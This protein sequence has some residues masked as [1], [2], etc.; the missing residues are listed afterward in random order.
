MRT[1]CC[2]YF[3]WADFSLSNL[4]KISKTSVRSLHQ[5]QSS[6]NTNKKSNASEKKRSGHKG[7]HAK[8]NSSVNQPYT[9]RKIPY[10]LS[11]LTGNLAEEVPSGFRISP[12][13]FEETLTIPKVSKIWWE[14]LKI[15]RKLLRQI[16]RQIK[17]GLCW[18]FA[19]NPVA[20]GVAKGANDGRVQIRENLQ[21]GTW[22]GAW[23]P[24]SR[25]A[26]VKKS[27]CGTCPLRNG[28]RTL[29]IQ[30]DC[31]LV[32]IAKYQHR[33]TLP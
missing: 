10:P 25:G 26:C 2:F 11:N 21:N 30:I 18:H 15:W 9:A 27:A 24:S 31:E 23:E 3:F 20:N 22:G 19:K 28:V 6:K 8:H 17:K 7:L 32:R 1:Y 4:G 16:L 5:K 14:R 13:E 12:S 33:K 29:L